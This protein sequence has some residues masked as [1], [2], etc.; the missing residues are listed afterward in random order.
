MTGAWDLVPS[1]CLLLRV[2]CCLVVKK[3]YYNPLGDRDYP[4]AL[5]KRGCKS[6]L[7]WGRSW[8]HQQ[9]QHFCSHR[10]PLTLSWTW[11]P[12]HSMDRGTEHSLEVGISGQNS[13]RN[14]GVHLCLL[15][16]ES[17]SVLISGWRVK[18]SGSRFKG[19]KSFLEQEICVLLRWSRFSCQLSLSA[20]C[21]CL[22]HVLQSLSCP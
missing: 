9:P 21:S 12:P 15:C 10:R 8:Y 5:C 4:D 1:L 19:K 17:C 14:S 18:L 13:G 11:R 7:I 6:D 20:C 16:P 2:F 3:R 22:R